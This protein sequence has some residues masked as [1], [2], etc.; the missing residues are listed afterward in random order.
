MM[1][2]KSMTRV[3][4]QYLCSKARSVRLGQIAAVVVNR[5]VTRRPKNVVVAM[6]NEM[7]RTMRAMLAHKRR[8]NLG[9]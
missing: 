3:S 5:I 7:A 6:A 2:G 8:T 1:L 4:K 9:T